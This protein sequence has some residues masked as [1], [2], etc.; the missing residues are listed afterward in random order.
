MDR[1]LG[2][3]HK[4]PEGQYLEIFVRS[5]RSFMNAPLGFTR[6]LAADGLR[7]VSSPLEN[8]SDSLQLSAESFAA[9]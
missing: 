5:L 8:F 9:D 7:S 4:R 1:I 2:R 6:G 3:V